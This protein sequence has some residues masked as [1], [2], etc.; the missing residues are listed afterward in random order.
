MGRRGPVVM[1]AGS[2]R[3]RAATLTG[4]AGNSA[5]SSLQHSRPVRSSRL[6]AARITRGGPEV[7][8][9]LAI[10][11]VHLLPVAP[12]L[13]L[14]TGKMTVVPGCVPVMG[15]PAV[16]MPVA[17][18]HRAA[19]TCVPVMAELLLQDVLMCVRGAIGVRVRFRL[20]SAIRFPTG[21]RPDSGTMVTTISDIG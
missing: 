5:R 16:R 8:Q 6:P 9:S 15:D 19:L 3:A 11:D 17:D 20:R 18:L 1:S 10:R 21:V 13:P 12:A 7:L 14:L 2:L 4:S